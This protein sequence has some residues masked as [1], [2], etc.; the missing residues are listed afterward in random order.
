MLYKYVTFERK[1]ILEHQLIRFTQPG[2][3][4]DPFEM[5][6]SFDLMSKADLAAKGSTHEKLKAMLAALW[7]GIQRQISTTAQEPGLWSLKNNLI[8]RSVF[9][10][11]YG[12]LCLTK[13]PSNLLMWAHYA[14]HHRG[15]VIQFDETHDFFRLSINAHSDIELGA[16]KYSDVCPILSYSSL[17]SPVIFYTKSVEWSY[18]VERRFIK[19]LSEAAKVIDA[20]TDEPLYPRCLFS[21]P[22]EAITGV[23]LGA[24]MP[25]QHQEA[26]VN[27]LTCNEFKHVNI[28]YAYLRA[29]LNIQ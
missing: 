11:K 22:G 8:A 17:E 12:I 21:V 15:M 2:C 14:N 9:D 20:P 7:P 27:L 5:H 3:F 25:S 19:P 28:Y 23:I 18:E 4:N 16:V 6:P 10:E 29:R 24:C 26:I 13:S 1:D